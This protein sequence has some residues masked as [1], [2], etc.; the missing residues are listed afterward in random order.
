MNE[1][2]PILVIDGDNVLRYGSNNYHN[3]KKV[4]LARL[5]KIIKD[6]EQ[7]GLDLILLV[8]AKTRYYIDDP[9]Q[10]EELLSRGV[11]IEIPARTQND[12]YILEIAKKFKAQI[13]SNDLFREYSN[14]YPKAIKQRLPF[15]ILRDRLIIPELNC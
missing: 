2:R 7:K 14:K 13:L 6:L 12:L 10:Y 11:I 3:Q 9:K 15:M 4:E 8:S 1:N 5:L